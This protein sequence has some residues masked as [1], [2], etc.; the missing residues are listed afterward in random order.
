MDVVV[1]TTAN[2]GTQLGTAHVSR[3][4]MCATSL[5]VVH[6][7]THLKIFICEPPG[8]QLVGGANFGLGAGGITVYQFNAL[9]PIEC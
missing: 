2:S 4:N 5:V 9:V 7:A 1:T 8:I 6:D 3:A